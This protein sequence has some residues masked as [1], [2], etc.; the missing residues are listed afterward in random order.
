MTEYY[1]RSDQSVRIGARRHEHSN[2]T[3]SH[4]VQPLID[5]DAIVLHRHTEVLSHEQFR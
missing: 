1:P 4:Q 2:S 5:L 3:L